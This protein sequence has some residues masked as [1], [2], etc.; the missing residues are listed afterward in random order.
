M[1]VPFLIGFLAAFPAAW[2]AVATTRP[3]APAVPLLAALAATIPLGVL[4]PS[5]MVTRGML[6]AVVVLGWAAVRARR[7]EA[8]VG[9]ARGSVPAATAAVLT[10]VLVSALAGLLVPDG[11]VSDRVLLSGRNDTPLVADTPVLP[12]RRTDD[13]R[14][15]TASGRPRRSSATARPCWTCTTV[16][17]G[18]RRR[19]RRVPTGTGRSSASGPP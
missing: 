12:A 10:V 5:L 8:L 6:V 9:A 13:I 7:R 2:L 19:T 3:L 18:Y 15:F 14:L 16:P 11:D 1:L 4:A 17:P